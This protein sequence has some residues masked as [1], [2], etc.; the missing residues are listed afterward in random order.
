MNYREYAENP[1]KV[2]VDNDARVIQEG[3]LSDGEGTQ[4]PDPF[5]PQWYVVWKHGVM[6]LG[7]V[8]LLPEKYAKIQG[9]LFIHLYL[10]GIDAGEAD[11]IASLYASGRFWFENRQRVYQL[12][13]IGANEQV[14][15]S[16]RLW[17]SKEEADAAHKDF[18]QRCV[19]YNPMMRP[20]Q[21]TTTPLEIRRGK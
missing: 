20:T 9:A 2:L 19:Q 13:G 21:I 6:H 15:F 14:I 16:E 4:I 1:G 12:R 10:S 8:E 5:G 3:T 17:Y 18:E 7:P 11:E